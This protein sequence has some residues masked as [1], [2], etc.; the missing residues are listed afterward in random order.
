MTSLKDIISHLKFEL[1]KGEH[2]DKE[3]IVSLVD[4]I[5]PLASRDWVRI[6]RLERRMEAFSGKSPEALE[7]VIGE[8]ETLK[9]ELET[10]KPPH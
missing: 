8:A 3:L 10:T 2:G 7:K 6:K 9:A 4:R 1:D 5:E